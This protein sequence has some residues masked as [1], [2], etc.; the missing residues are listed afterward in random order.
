MLGA[1]GFSAALYDAYLSAPG[2]FEVL[3]GKG[4]IWQEFRL[5]K[6]A[7]GFEAVYLTEKPLWFY[8]LRMKTPAGSVERLVSAPERIEKIPDDV[9]SR[10]KEIHFTDSP[11]SLTRHM[12]FP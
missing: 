7:D 9:K 11:L 4:G 12:V 3:P 5:K 2:T 1:T 10:L 8:G 6:S